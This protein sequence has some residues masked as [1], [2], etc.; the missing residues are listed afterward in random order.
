GQT[1]RDATSPGGWPRLASIPSA[2]AAGPAP[3]PCQPHARPAGSAWV[4]ARREAL[5]GRRLERGMVGDLSG[6]NGT[7]ERD[8][9]EVLRRNAR[10]HHLRL[11]P[12]AEAGVVS[13]LPRKLPRQAGI[14]K[15]EL[16]GTRWRYSAGVGSPS[17]SWGRS[18]WESSIHRDAASRTS[19]RRVNRC[20]FRTSSR[21][22]RL[23]RSM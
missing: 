20:W 17:E 4:K 8:D 2:P 15:V 12:E 23:K 5:S 10:Q 9:L 6:G 18:S 3:L 7:M 11:G 21:K 13:G 14:S 19:S 22:V 16:P 1:P